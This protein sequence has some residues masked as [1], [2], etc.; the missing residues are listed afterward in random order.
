VSKFVKV[1]FL[2]LRRTVSSKIALFATLAFIAC[3]PSEKLPQSPSMVRECFLLMG[4]WTCFE[5]GCPR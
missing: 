5:K 3:S 1:S 2:E 4:D